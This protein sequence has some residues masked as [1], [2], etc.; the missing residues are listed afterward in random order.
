MSPYADLCVLC[1]PPRPLRFIPPRLARGGGTRP[2]EDGSSAAYAGH[3]LWPAVL[4]P[5]G[6]LPS[7]TDSLE[8][9]RSGQ[10]P[11]AQGAAWTTT[12][13]FEF[14]GAENRLLFSAHP[15]VW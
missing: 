14:C 11:K 3:L 13:D 5:A 4:G 2:K 6:D 1:V 15:P 12:R 9:R 8:S 10:A 7:A